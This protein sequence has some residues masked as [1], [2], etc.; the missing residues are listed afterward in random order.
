MNLLTRRESR[1]QYM[2]SMLLESMVE[3]NAKMAELVLI[4]C[5]LAFLPT[6]PHLSNTIY[7]P[8]CLY[9]YLLGR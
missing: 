3:E 6:V 8:I 5:T 2:Y 1:Q 4:L 9:Q 7:P